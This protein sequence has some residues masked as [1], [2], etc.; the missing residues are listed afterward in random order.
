MYIKSSHVFTRFSYIWF[1][2]KSYYFYRFYLHI[3]IPIKR[4]NTNKKLCKVFSFFILLLVPFQR[5]GQFNTIIKGF[6]VTSSATS[7]KYLW[8]LGLSFCAWKQNH[9]S[10]AYILAPILYFLFKEKLLL[11]SRLEWTLMAQFVSV[12]LQRAACLSFRQQCPKRVISHGCSAV[13]WR[14]D[15]FLYFC[16]SLCFYAIPPNRLLNFFSAVIVILDARLVFSCVKSYESLPY[17]NGYYSAKN[18]WNTVNT[19]EFFNSF[20]F[21]HFKTF[22]ICISACNFLW[23]F[24]VLLAT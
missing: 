8:A 12:T 9:W 7:P 14:W 10:N 24:F 15:I 11:L 23:L 17:V 19:E 16:A 18:H 2:N 13:A 4:R 20:I 6:G 3:F 21:F 5:R 1:T 22:F